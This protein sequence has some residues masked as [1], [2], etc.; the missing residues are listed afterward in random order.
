MYR[1]I[2]LDF[3]NT[4]MDFTE[5][6]RRALSDTFV[7]TYGR[8]LCAEETT[9]YN[10]INDGY[11]KRLERKEVTREELKVGRF[12]DFLLHLGLPQEDAATVNERYM[13]TL[14]ETVVE[15]PESFAA[16]R[17]LAKHYELYI[18]SNGTAYIQHARMAKASF[19][20]FFKG[21]FISEEVGVN[22]PAPEFF[23]PIAKATGDSDRSHYLMVGD[24]MSSDIRFGKNVGID[25]CYVGTG[26]NDADYSVSGI[27]ELPSLSILQCE[28]EE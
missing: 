10:R 4:L 16:C 14:A 1:Y 9:A 28:T 21:V 26:V 27:G 18:V 3:D 13:N 17:E 7:K 24:S 6:E 8:E 20:S 22:K 23:E 5:S 15:Y 11:W 25:T 2:L 12:R 19:R